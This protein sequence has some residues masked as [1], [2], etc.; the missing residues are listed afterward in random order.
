VKVQLALAAILLATGPAAAQ[1]Y[2]GR[3]PTTNW[4]PIYGPVAPKPIGSLETPKTPGFTP[5]RPQSVYSNRGGVNAYPQPNR[6]Y[7][8][9]KSQFGRDSKPSW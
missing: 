2:G 8:G 7:T 5:Y 3:Q 4:S 1:G 9:V 6:P